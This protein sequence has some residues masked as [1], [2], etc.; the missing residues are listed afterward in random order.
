MKNSERV[1]KNNLEDFYGWLSVEENLERFN[2]DIG[3]ELDLVEEI[4]NED[5]DQYSIIMEEVTT[6]NRVLIEVASNMHPELNFEKV[7]RRASEIFIDAKV[8]IWLT[9]GSGTGFYQQTLDW[10]NMITGKQ[11]CFMHLTDRDCRNM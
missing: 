10:I 4:R 1:Y 11:Y 3:F 5:E 8:V 7:L 2:K 6:K 9:D